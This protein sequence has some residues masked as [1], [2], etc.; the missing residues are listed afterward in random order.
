MLVI[1]L[2]LAGSHMSKVYEENTRTMYQIQSKLALQKRKN[3]KKTS[4]DDVQMFLYL[5]I[6]PAN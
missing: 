3:R 4:I 5:S 2:R 1:I 6:H